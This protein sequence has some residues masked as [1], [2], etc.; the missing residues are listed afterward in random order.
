MSLPIEEYGLLSN[1]HTAALVSRHGSVDWLCF[2]RFDSPSVFGRLLDPYAGHWSITISDC[3]ER[4]RFYRPASLVLETTHVGASGTVVVSDA[5]AFAHHVRHHDIG[6]DSPPV[7]L[8]IVECT[9]GKAEILIDFCPRFEY[10]LLEP[11]LHQIDGGVLGYAGAS[12]FVFSTDLPFEIENGTVRI[13]YHLHEGQRA[14]FSLEYGSMEGE[15]PRPWTPQR[16]S[17]RLDDTAAAWESWSKIHQTYVGPWK[18]LVLHSG[19][20]LQGLVYQPTGAIVAAATTSLPETEG[21][22]RNWDYRYSWVRDASLT[23]EAFW[24][25]ACPVESTRFFRYLTRA[26]ATHSGSRYEIPVLFGIGGEH[27]LSERT[28]PHLAGWNDSKPVRVGN[29]AWTQRQLDLPG[30]LLRSADVLSEQM[31]NMDEQTRVFLV[32]AADG[33]AAI[34]RE[35]DQGIW[36]FR[37]EPRHFLH[38]KLMCWTAL[39]SA[40]H[41]VSLLKA[42]ERLP[43]WI[44]TREE[45]KETILEHGWNK[46]VQAFTQAF[47]SAELDASSLLIPIVGFLPGN[48]VRVLETIRAIVANLTDARGL[49]YRYRAEDGLTGQE[50]AFLLCTFWLAQAQALAGQL[51]AAKQTFQRAAGFANDLHLFSEQIHPET[52]ALL[53]NFPQA[54]SHI[55]L[56]NAAYGIAQAE[57]REH[58]LF[59]KTL[60]VS[61]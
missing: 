5:L 7:L 18:D 61:A 38:S 43:D 36:E 26:A 44:R 2:P 57:S 25:A 46:D 27:D 50:G 13:R 60:E 9:S 8:R 54:F 32:E 45:I 51:D 56:I 42:E 4:R 14:R 48:D 24:I 40:I 39:D 59:E 55:G 3:T 37:S 10:G 22:D 17:E 28:L 29:D 35:T 41:L 52:S 31:Q 34:W 1:C 6:K 15:T 33:A 30:E 12:A 53:G 16:I 23:M 47:G 20:V 19:R 49:V 58:L 11:R 21:G